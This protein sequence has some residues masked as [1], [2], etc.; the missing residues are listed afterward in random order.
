MGNHSNVFEI[1]L[2]SDGK[3]FSHHYTARTAKQAAMRA[4]GK[5]KILS[6]RKVHPED[7]IGSIKSMNLQGIIGVRP[8]EARSVIFDETTIDSIVFPHKT[9]R[10]D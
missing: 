2:K 4:N 10:R 1:R 7:I 3:I 5:G 8:K 6:V 9:K